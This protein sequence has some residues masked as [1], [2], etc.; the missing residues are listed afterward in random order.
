MRWLLLAQFVAWLTAAAAPH[1]VTAAT[2]A[3]MAFSMVPGHGSSLGSCWLRLLLGYLQPL[4]LAWL[5]L[6]SWAAA[7]PQVVKAAAACVAFSSVPGL[8]CYSGG[9]W[10]RLLLGWSW[11]LGLPQWPWL[12]LLTWLFEWLLDTA[13]PWA[14]MKSGCCSCSFSH[15]CS[16]QLVF[17]R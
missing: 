9:R 8:G 15:C 5:F 1:V 2:T 4:L 7:A 6:C 13:T 10:W 14:F 3:C 17:G 11:A 12:L 16:L